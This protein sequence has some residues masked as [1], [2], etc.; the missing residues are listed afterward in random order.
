MKRILITLW[1][2]SMLFVLPA[3]AHCPDNIQ[4]PEVISSGAPATY[5]ASNDMPVFPDVPDG[6]WYTEEVR[7]CVGNGLMDGTSPAAFSPDEPATRAVLVTALYRQA[8]TPACPA[9]DQLHRCSCW[10]FLC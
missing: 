7:Y 10:G 4:Q 8:G 1:V 3:C 6:A 5:A 9:R 2:L